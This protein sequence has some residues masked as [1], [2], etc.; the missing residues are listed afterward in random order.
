MKTANV[1]VVSSGHMGLCERRIRPD[2]C[3]EQ[4]FWRSF[5]LGVKPVREVLHSKICVEMFG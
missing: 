3:G 1:E 5:D 2:L 4:D